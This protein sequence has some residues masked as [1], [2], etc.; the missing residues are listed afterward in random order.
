M[1]LKSCVHIEE[2]FVTVSIRT[3]ILRKI[4]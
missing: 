2:V 1:I 3:G 4:P